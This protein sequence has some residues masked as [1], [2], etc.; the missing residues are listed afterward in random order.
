MY[1]PPDADKYLEVPVYQLKPG[2][3]VAYLDR[4]WL[5][6]PFMVQGFF[7]H[8][9]QDINEVADVCTHVFVDPRRVTRGGHAPLQVLGGNTDNQTTD[10]TV[11]LRRDFLKA[12]ADYDIATNGVKLAFAR[13][14]ETGH[15]SVDAV[16]AAIN[17]L[18]D[19]VVHRKEA[20][21][22]LVRMK[23]KADYLYNH[24]IA[25]AVLGAMIGH[26]LG[27]PTDDLENLTLGCALMDVGKVKLP[28][29]MLNSTMALTPTQSEAMRKHIQFGLGLVQ[30]E[31]RIDP[32]VEAVIRDHHERWDGSG[33]PG[34][35]VGKE[36]PLVAQVA[37]LVDSYDAMTT[38][39][40]YAPTRSSFET[41]QELIDQKDIK[42]SGVLVE[43]FVQS[44]GLFPTGSLVQLSTGEVGIV[45]AQNPTR[46]LKPKIV[47]VLDAN[48]NRRTDFVTIDLH[49][50]MRAD[51]T[52]PVWITAELPAGSFGIDR[53][54]LYL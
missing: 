10:V 44:I 53:E 23:K 54:A 49:K 50:Y 51:G 4:P 1:V 11:A 36:I 30:R 37:G 45:V 47:V 46:R 5:E 43:Q 39:R 48:K 12:E 34:G 22:A 19:H 33:Y 8:T 20:M 2:M 40:P 27:M 31:G 15:I 52:T 32:L 38:Q 3:Y 24:S 28:D 6:S 14:R 21:V 7:V 13:L 9:Q 16:A 17:P 25:V 26:Q 29:E 42:F 41:V 35:K 18:I